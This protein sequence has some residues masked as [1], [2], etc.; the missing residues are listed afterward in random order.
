M[1]LVTAQLLKE[2]KPIFSTTKVLISF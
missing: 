1:S 2:T